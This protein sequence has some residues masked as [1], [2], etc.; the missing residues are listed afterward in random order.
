[1]LVIAPCPFPANRGTPSRI[2][3]MAES[4]LEYYS[5]DILTYPLDED[6]EV[7][8][9]LSIRRVRNVLGYDKR[10]PGPSFTKALLDM[11]MLPVLL[12][13]TRRHD[14]DV[15]YAHHVE[16]C[17]VGLA[18]KALSRSDAPLIYDVH[19]SLTDEL[20]QF[21]FLYNRLTRPAW[22]FLED[23]LLAGA[24]RL[25]CVSDELRSTVLERGLAREEDVTVV[26]TGIRYDAFRAMIDD[27]SPFD[28]PGP[29]VTYAGSMAPYQNL[30]ELPAVAEAVSE[31]NSLVRF[32]VVA[33]EV[34]AAEVRA[35]VREARERDVEDRLDVRTG[36][37]FPDVPTYLYHSD[38]LVNLRTEC[39]GV[40]QK[41]VNYMAAGRPMVSAA[42][43]AKPLKDG[44]NAIVVTDHDVAAFADAVHELLTDPERA[45]RLGRQAAKDARAFDWDRLAADLGQFLG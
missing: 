21:G 10:S 41:L 33:G 37:D 27:E 8:P 44:R 14:Y 38:I 6:V 43:S 32:C 40:P 35:V 3:R 9:A 7:D 29:T 24:D 18:W 31:G 15:L 1:M 4:L 2:L 45:E 19:G 22:A 42:G 34:E 28:H 39:T 13:L 16:G 11:E 30:T 12:D 17:A 5:I 23:R 20:E 36:V 26:P 25:V